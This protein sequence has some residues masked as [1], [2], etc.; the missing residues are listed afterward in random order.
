MTRPASPRLEPTTSDEWDDETVAL[1]DA[2]GHLNIFTTL[3]HHPKLLKRWMVFGGHV[4]G[5]NTLTA[6]DRELLI[7]RAGWRCG[8]AYEFGQHTVIGHRS[9]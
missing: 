8:C 1:L 5:K 2:V 6:R 7:L 3:A 9:G 4:L